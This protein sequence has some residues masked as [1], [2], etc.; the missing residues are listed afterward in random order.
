MLSIPTMGTS[1]S[2]LAISMMFE[3]TVFQTKKGKEKEDVHFFTATEGE[4]R[5]WVHHISKNIE[6]IQKAKEENSLFY[7]LVYR[8]DED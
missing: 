5:Y 2:S 4:L 7:T 3:F 1:I 8:E 6:N